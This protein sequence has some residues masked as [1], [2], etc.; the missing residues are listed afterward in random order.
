MHADETADAVVIG[1]GI[2]GAASAYELARAGLRVTLLERG[3]LAGE[4]S[5]RNGGGVRAQGRHPGWLPLAR[6]ALRRWPGLDDELGAPTGF[7]PGG[8]LTV[9]LDEAELAVL[10]EAAESQRA[11]GLGCELL[12]A[13]QSRR[14]V[15][16]LTERVRGALLAPGDGQADPVLSTRAFAQAAER[17]GARVREGAEVTGIAVEGG[18]VAAVSTAERTIGAEWVVCAAGPWAARV[19]ALLGVEIPIMPRRIQI[20]EAAPAPSLGV[21]FL[22]G[23]GLYLRDTAA[24]ALHAGGTPPGVV[25]YIGYEKENDPAYVAFIRERLAGLLPAMAGACTL[26]AWSGIVEQ[27]QDGL[28]IV[29]RLGEPSGLV[30]AAGFNGHG[31]G[32]GPAIGQTVRELVVDGETTVPLAPLRL[33]RFA[34]GTLAALHTAAAAPTQSPGPG[35]WLRGWF[36]GHTGA[37]R[38][39]VVT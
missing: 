33:D 16:A 1:G 14:L 11:H 34:P 24:G 12:D 13:R 10:A 29:D 27:T 25:P 17:H 2:A 23:N 26:R 31:F 38:A 32:L 35:D 28:P 15:P 3:V 21:A 4:A 37:D 9:A 39:R 22:V 30:V 6:L 19:G 20:L 8:D 36:R 18:R 7:R 5:G